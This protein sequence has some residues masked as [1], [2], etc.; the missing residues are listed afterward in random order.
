MRRS[1]NDGDHLPS[2][3]PLVEYELPIVL[4]VADKLATSTDPPQRC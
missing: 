2:D 4:E 1:Y 3:L